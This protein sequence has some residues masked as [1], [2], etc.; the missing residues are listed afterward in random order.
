SLPGLTRQ[1]MPFPL[2]FAERP[3]EWM[4]GSGPG[5]TKIEGA[6]DRPNGCPGAQLQVG[7]QG[8]R[9]HSDRHAPRIPDTT[10][11]SQE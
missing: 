1:S 9:C 7:N 11:L 3:V 6:V 4:P 2:D 8:R 10:V 5:M